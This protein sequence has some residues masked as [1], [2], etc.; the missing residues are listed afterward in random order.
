MRRNEV[1]NWFIERKGYN[2]YLEIG[3][4]NPNNCINRIKAVRKVGVDPVKGGT[5]KMT[6]DHF[7][8]INKEMFDII[9][10]DGLHI[11]DQVERDIYNSIKC[12]KPKGTIIVHDLH[13]QNELEQKV[14]REVQIWTGNGWKAWAKIRATCSNLKMYTIDSDHGIGVIRRG[15]QKLYTGPYEIYQDFVNNKKEILKLKNPKEIY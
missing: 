4:D 11:E 14:P 1:I 2:S 10:I 8:S 6:S 9:F 7:F 13:P 5:H 12:L 3:V 15:K